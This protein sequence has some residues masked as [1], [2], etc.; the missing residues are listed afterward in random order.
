ML[1]PRGADKARTIVAD[2][3]IDGGGLRR[4]PVTDATP[5]I[6]DLLTCG[7]ARLDPLR[8]SLDTTPD[9][10]V[11]NKTGQPSRCIF[12]VGPAARGALSEITAIPDIR[13]QTFRLANELLSTGAEAAP[14]TP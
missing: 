4:D 13:E 1:A 6:R 5:V 8:L 12:E 3:V 9:A 11:I 2:Q 10:H 7:A 14:G